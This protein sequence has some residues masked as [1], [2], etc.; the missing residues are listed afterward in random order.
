MRKEHDRLLETEAELLQAEKA[1]SFRVDGD[2]FTINGKSAVVKFENPDTEHVEV[3]RESSF[4]MKANHVN[5]TY[6]VTIKGEQPALV[7][8][9]SYD[10][11]R[12][13][14]TYREVGEA[15][16]GP[17]TNGR[18]SDAYSGKLE[19]G[20][21]Q[22]HITLAFEEGRVIEKTAQHLE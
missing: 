14:M 21:G 15:I 9:E 7:T 4:Q 18:M 1:W 19:L 20:Q 10:R 8:K 2:E 11:I 6:S 5:V 22:R 3:K 17:M 13:G 16:G 12:T